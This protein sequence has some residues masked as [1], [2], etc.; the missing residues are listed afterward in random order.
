MMSL[1]VLA[2]VNNQI[3]REAAREGLVPYIPAS[4]D[5]VESPW[6][7]PNIGYLQPRGWARAGASWFVDKTGVGEPWEPALT[8]QQFRKRLTGYILRHPQD[9]FAITEEGE[10]QCVVSAFKR[11]RCPE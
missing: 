6:F 3:A 1:E 10:Y 5:E 11:V 7:L 9:G 2:A 8:W 4:A